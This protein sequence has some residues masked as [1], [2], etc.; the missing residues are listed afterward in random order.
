MW[1][2]WPNIT[3]HSLHSEIGPSRIDHSSLISDM[4][5]PSAA[6]I[7]HGAALEPNR[8]KVS[9]TSETESLHF[10]NVRVEAVKYVRTRSLQCSVRSVVVPV[11]HTTETPVESITAPSQMEI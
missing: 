4:S 6:T 9:N 5:L 10:C 1:R 2:S 11:L 3:V 8:L 7:S